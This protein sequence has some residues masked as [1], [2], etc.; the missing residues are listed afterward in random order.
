MRRIEALANLRS[1]A[2]IR[3]S[4]NYVD[5][6]DE[7]FMKM[8]GKEATIKKPYNQINVDKKV[9]WFVYERNNERCNL[10]YDRRQG[11]IDRWERKHA[12][13]IYV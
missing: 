12:N 9:A 4:E 2:V 6:N 1:D 11:E 5:W 3:T 10:A 8:T 13:G 7:R